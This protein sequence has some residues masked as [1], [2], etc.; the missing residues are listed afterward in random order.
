MDK[1]GN[2]SSKKSSI[3]T[4]E[5]F[6]KLQKY[7]KNTIKDISKEILDG[8]IELRLRELSV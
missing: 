7:V 6:E 8:N 1:D 5:E 4:N 3:A 2:L